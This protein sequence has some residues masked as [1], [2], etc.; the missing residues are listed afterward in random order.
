MPE[1]FDLEWI[2]KQRP[3][4]II[5]G[6]SPDTPTILDGLTSSDVINRIVGQ[7]FAIVVQGLQQAITEI[8]DVT[9]VEING[10][11]VIVYNIDSSPLIL[12]FVNKA[13]AGIAVTRL[14]TILNG[15]SV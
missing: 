3:S 15:G 9:H 12:N 7:S 14:T 13:E 6:T 8:N 1:G 2:Q 11:R 5:S 4:T 10:R